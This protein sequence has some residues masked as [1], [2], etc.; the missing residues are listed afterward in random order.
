MP[1]VRSFQALKRIMQLL[2]CQR[3]VL[4]GATRSGGKRGTPASGWC[5][6]VPASA[7]ETPLHDLKSWLAGASNSSGAATGEPTATAA[8][9]QTRSPQRLSGDG[10]EAAAAEEPEDEA[11]ADEQEDEHLRADPVRNFTRYMD[12]ADAIIQAA[13]SKGGSEPEEKKPGVHVEIVSAA[14]QT[15][16]AGRGGVATGWSVAKEATKPRQRLLLSTYFGWKRLVISTTDGSLL[17]AASPPATA[18]RKVHIP[19]DTIVAVA[20][21]GAVLEVEFMVMPFTDSYSS[22]KRRLQR[23]HRSFLEDQGANNAC[24]VRISFADETAA[25]SA[26]TQLR[27]YAPDYAAKWEATCMCSG[28]SDTRLATLRSARTAARRAKLGRFAQLHG[29]QDELQVLCPAALQRAAAQPGS[30]HC[31]PFAAGAQAMVRLCIRIYAEYIAFEAWALGQCAHSGS[32][33]LLGRVCHCVCSGRWLHRAVPVLVAVA[34]QD[35]GG[36]PVIYGKMVCC[37]CGD[38]VVISKQGKVCKVVMEGGKI[39][40]VGQHAGE[41]HG[42]CRTCDVTGCPTPHVTVSSGSAGEASGGADEEKEAEEA[43]AV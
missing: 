1:M 31:Q 38:H 35:A 16:E 33:P 41:P 24:R 4:M 36:A 12:A 42:I 30:C 20:V 29:K 23:D 19:Y 21:N 11:D 28:L 34:V 39:A 2:W 43:G 13:A 26:A 5:K 32:C 25:T 17:D 14:I 27:G 3:L 40:P 7:N 9:A 15:V 8:A 37:G 22:T 6:D 10:A 18:A